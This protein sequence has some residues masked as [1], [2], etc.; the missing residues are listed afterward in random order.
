MNLTD[1]P[2]PPTPLA[3]WKADPISI[4]ALR[5]LLEK[6]VFAQACAIIVDNAQPT[7]SDLFGS[8]DSL[9]RKHCWLAGYGDFLRDLQKLTK[10]PSVMADQVPWGHFTDTKNFN[11][12]ADQSGDGVA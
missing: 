8:T 11:P 4:L 2:T 9:A 10:M 3:R 5:E 12:H 1:N 7:T 6:P